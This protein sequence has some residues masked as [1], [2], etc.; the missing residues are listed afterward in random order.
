MHRCLLACPVFL[1]AGLVCVPRCHPAPAP[2]PAFLTTG[3]LTAADL[4]ALP[5]PTP[6]YEESE[7]YGS[8]QTRGFTPTVWM[9]RQRFISGESIPTFFM[10]RNH[11]PDARGLDMRLDLHRSM[12]Q[13]MNGASLTFTNLDT[14][15]PVEYLRSHVSACGGHPKL[16]IPA[17]GYYVVRAD[18]GNPDGK[19]LPPG[20]Y[21]VRWR[22]LDIHSAES[23]FTV[24]VP[25]NSVEVRNP[26]SARPNL[27]W[28]VVQNHGPSNWKPWKN[29]ELYAFEG[30]EV[31][32]VLGSG[33]LGRYYPDPFDLRAC[34]DLVRVSVVLKSERRLAV[35]L[36]PRW[37]GDRVAC[38][39]EIHVALRVACDPR[40]ESENVRAMEWGKEGDGKH[41]AERLLPRALEV[42]LPANWR[43]KIGRGLVGS[44]KVAVVVSSRHLRMPDSRM[45][46]MHVGENKRSKDSAPEWQGVLC[47]P[48]AECPSTRT[49]FR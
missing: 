48:L 17:R 45:E 2:G 19:P 47:A 6:T 34:D 26:A 49:D 35:T 29:A 10:L 12:P 31:A 9:P 25:G 44:G 39:Q 28:W 27:K 33:H 32:A 30:G 11:L 22:Y 37:I 13:L 1:L 4:A 41:E 21:G 23:R 42:T 43:E 15:K 16:E 7:R 3:F 8:T 38:P 5:W 24:R 40:E 18:L 46:K 20:R 36:T 14:G